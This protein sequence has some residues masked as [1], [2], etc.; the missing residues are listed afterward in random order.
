MRH[1]EIRRDNHTGTIVVRH[2]ID[3]ARPWIT[4]WAWNVDLWGS[5]TDE[6]VQTWP[7]LNPE[8]LIRERKAHAKAL[9]RQNG[10]LSAVIGD[11]R[12]Q[13]ARERERRREL[14][15]KNRTIVELKVTKEPE[16]D[17]TPRPEFSWA[18]HL[19]RYEPKFDL[20]NLLTAAMSKSHVD[21]LQWPPFDDTTCYTTPL[22]TRVHVNRICTC[23]REHC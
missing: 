22:G 15:T 2:G 9:Q 16:I 4:I 18:D 10:K 12:A 21:D 23:R 7:V 5:Y 14:E 20:S 8:Y 13:L 11:L 6:H 3:L 1:P 19:P 17:F